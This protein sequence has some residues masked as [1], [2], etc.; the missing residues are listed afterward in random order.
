MPEVEITLTD[1]DGVERARPTNFE[2]LRVQIPWMDSRIA[3]VTAPMHDIWAKGDAGVASM[4]PFLHVLKVRYRSRLVFHGV[5][6]EPEW[7]FAAGTVTLHAIDPSIFLMHHYLQGNEAAVTNA[8]PADYRA[9][10]ALVNAARLNTAETDA[11]YRGPGIQIGANYAAD[12]VRTRRA[13]LGAEVWGELQEFT[14]DILSP[15]WL[16][17]PVDDRHPVGD[18]SYVYAAG[19]MVRFNTYAAQG[20]SGGR[21]RDLTTG[22]QAVDLHF[23]WGA[24]NIEDVVYRPGG[25]NMRNRFTAVDNSETVVAGKELP[26]RFWVSRHLASLRARGIIEGRETPEGR[27]QDSVLQGYADAQIKAYGIPPG[28][29]TVQPRSE[30]GKLGS[31]YGA[32]FRYGE[33]YLENDRIK[34]QARKGRKSIDLAGRISSV[35]LLQR[36]STENVKAELEMIPYSAVE[37][38]DISTESPGANGFPSHND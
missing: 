32:P 4:E 28:Y 12:T 23:G 8:T 19:D 7:S 5:L 36:D 33:S 27:K 30:Q 25:A 26:G 38:A 35:T 22:P 31:E 15:Q 14:S 11:L 24:D 3:E 37:D 20:A 34:V 16:L 18:A 2:G 21:G 17:E 13:P 1:R 29:F 6:L 9:S 10:R